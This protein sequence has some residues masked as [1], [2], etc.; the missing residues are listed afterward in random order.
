[1]NKNLPIRR[2]A[3]MTSRVVIQM[4]FS[5][6]TLTA[7]RAII[8]FVSGM[9]FHVTFERRRIRKDVKANGAGKHGSTQ[10][11]FSVTRQII[12]IRERFAAY[13]KSLYFQYQSV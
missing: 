13:L 12:R 5:R 3:S 4:L 11:T 2:L 10:M 1:M 7:N 8:R 9:S 6:E